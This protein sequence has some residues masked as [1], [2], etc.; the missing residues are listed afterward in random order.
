MPEQERVTRGQ[1]MRFFQTA[2]RRGPAGLRKDWLY[3]NLKPMVDAL[4]EDLKDA[5][6]EAKIAPQQPQPAAV[7]QVPQEPAKDQP[8][9]EAEAVKEEPAKKADK[10]DLGD[11]PKKPA[12]KGKK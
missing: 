8:Q 4:E 1:F 9:A 3:T 2:I 5:Q 11:N 10:K 12:R 6:E 7:E